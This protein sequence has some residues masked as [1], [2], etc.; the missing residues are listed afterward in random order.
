MPNVSIQDNKCWVCNERAPNTVHHGLPQHLKPVFNVTIPV[1]KECHE[2]INE[3]DVSG[4]IGFAYKI[5][6]NSQKLNSETHKLVDYVNHLSLKEGAF[7][8]KV[9]KKDEEK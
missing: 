5:M 7:L 3:S 9:I 2:K 1:C 4:M 6:K 8:D